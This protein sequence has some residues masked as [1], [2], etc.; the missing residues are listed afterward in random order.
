MEVPAPKSDNLSSV[1]ETHMEGG[2]RL[3]QDILRASLACT[4]MYTHV[5]CK[6]NAQSACFQECWQ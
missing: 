2:D 5:N 3:L 1:P 6:Y 4:H